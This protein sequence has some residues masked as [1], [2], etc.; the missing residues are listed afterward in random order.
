L[1]PARCARR[2][3]AN[4]RAEQDTAVQLVTIQMTS[5]DAAPLQKLP[6]AAGNHG[7]DEGNRLGS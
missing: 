4:D 1:Y 7:V 6:S 5:S 2:K 3:A